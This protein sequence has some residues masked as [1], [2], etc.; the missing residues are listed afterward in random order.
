MQEAGRSGCLWEMVYKCCVLTVTCQQ[1]FYLNTHS[2]KQEQSSNSSKNRGEI[3]S[4]YFKFYHISHVYW[5]SMWSL[6]SSWSKNKS[7]KNVSRIIKR[8]ELASSTEF[9]WDSAG[10]LQN[11]NVISF[12]RNMVAK[13]KHF[14]KPTFA[15]GMNY[16]WVF[17]T[18]NTSLLI[19]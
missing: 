7:H 12:R 2:A 15:S 19:L 3:L 17:T 13:L 18:F 11:I 16:F 6:N 9:L 8:T 5:V 10:L 1:S 4:V 14:C